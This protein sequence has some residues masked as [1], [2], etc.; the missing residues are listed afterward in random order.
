MIRWEAPSPYTV[1]FT[2]RIGGV[3][4]GPFA[5]LNLGRRTGDDI[6]RVDENRRIVCAEAGA[7]ADRLALNYQVH[8]T[9]V[10]RAVPGRRGT[11]G[12]ALWTDRTGLPILALSADCVPVA[13]VRT[14]GK[15]AAAVVH[16]GRIGI[17]AGTIAMAARSL[18]GM[19]AAALGPAAGP[20]CYEVGEEV[21]QP[22]R[23]RFGEDVARDG[24]LD[25]WAAAEKALREI[26]VTHVDRIDLCTICNPHLFFSHRR[27]GKPRGVQGVLALVG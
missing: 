17:L 12:D 8:G 10:N 18:G 4:Q 19:L 5:S 21:A 22:Y 23:Q 15:P 7:D 2:T 25:L 11:P 1:V 9:T 26:G 16:A 27:T 13:L 20:C 6:M 3:S 24:T 14:T